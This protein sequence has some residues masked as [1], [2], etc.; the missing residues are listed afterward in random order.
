MKTSYSSDSGSSS[1][2]PPIPD[3]VWFRP[4]EAA[5]CLDVRTQTVYKWIDTG[6]IRAVRIVGQLRIPRDEVL[7]IIRPATASD[8]TE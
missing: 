6:V 2:L 3:R 4:G 5:R 1:W 8:D 7:R